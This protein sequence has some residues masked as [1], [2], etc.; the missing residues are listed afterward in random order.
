M[1]RV[2]PEEAVQDFTKRFRAGT[3]YREYTASDDERLKGRIPAAVRLLLQRD[4]FSS[5]RD[6]IFWLCD[7]DDWTAVPPAWFPDVPNA[8]VLAR[9]SFGDLFVFGESM[10]MAMVHE[11]GTMP[12]ARDPSWFFAETVTSKGMFILDDIPKMTKAARQAAGS[13]AWNEIYTYVPALA[14][15][16]NRETSAIERVKAPEQLVI[17]SQLAPIKRM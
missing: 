13:L 10:W 15:G 14:L 5:Y 3:R 17:L 7:P 16:G 6:Q 11:A 12:S 1:A 2:T 4:G 8:Q 9:S